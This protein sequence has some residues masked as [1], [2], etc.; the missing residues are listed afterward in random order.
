MPQKPKSQNLDN[1]L[2]IGLL[3]LK[4]YVASVGHT[5]HEEGDDLHAESFTCALDPPFC[6]STQKKEGHDG[7]RS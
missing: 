2:D 6:L 5:S 4:S 1:V 7:A 3:V